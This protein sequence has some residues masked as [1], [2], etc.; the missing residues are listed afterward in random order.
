MIRDAGLS[1]APEDQPE[2][3]RWHFPTTLV[4]LI[5][6][7]D[8]RAIALEGQSTPQAWVSGPRERMVLATAT[9]YG[10]SMVA[11]SV[12][13]MVARRLFRGIGMHGLTGQPVIGISDL[14]GRDTSKLTDASRRDDWRQAVPEALAGLLAVKPRLNGEATAEHAWRTLCASGGRLRIEDLART[15]GWTRRHLVRQFTEHIGMTPKLAGRILRM[16]QAVALLDRG[17]PGSV[18]AAEAGYSD[19]AHFVRETRALTGRTP[20]A[21]LGQI[22]CPLHG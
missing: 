10:A 14:L 11:V 16:K 8:E 17:R 12:P 22:H 1:V 21:W 5:F 7:R 3:E 20:T 9:S 18:A 15:V 13:P 2:P 19:H 4:T 6:N